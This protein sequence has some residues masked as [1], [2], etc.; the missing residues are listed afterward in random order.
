MDDI[1]LKMRGEK[2]MSEEDAL[3]EAIDEAT[4]M[5][6]FW[7]TALA[8]FG[9]NCRDALIEHFG[10]ALWLIAGRNARHPDVQREIYNELCSYSLT[11]NSK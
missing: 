3:L 11:E 6:V 9:P 5:I 1:D 10:D 8:K 4:P 2:P 7:H